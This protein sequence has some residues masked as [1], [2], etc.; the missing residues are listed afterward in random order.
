MGTGS[1]VSTQEPSVPQAGGS[2]PGGN[3]RGPGVGSDL[4]VG[5]GMKG[6]GSQ[7]WNQAE[8]PGDQL[9]SLEG[10]ALVEPGVTSIT[11]LALGGHHLLAWGSGTRVGR[12]FFIDTVFII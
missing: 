1:Q 4:N 11:I 9:T 10:K 8:S 2:S 7:G 6:R 12:D 5:V 3:G